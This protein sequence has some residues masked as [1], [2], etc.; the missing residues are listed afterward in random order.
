MAVDPARKA[1]LQE[2]CAEYEAMYES[3]RADLVEVHE[4]MRELSETAYSADG[5]VAATVDAQGQLT[6]LQLDPRAF[7]T[8]DATT[9]AETITAT[10]RQAVAEVT[11]RMVE[12]ADPL[13]PAG[14]HLEIGAGLS[15]DPLVNQVIGVRKDG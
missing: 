12:L 7:R 6:E 5:L 2:M 4:N 1:L 13:M 8:S 3:L 9:L 15:F 10:V 14:H 11:T